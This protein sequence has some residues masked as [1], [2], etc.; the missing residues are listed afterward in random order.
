MDSRKGDM[1]RVGGGFPGKDAGSEDGGREMTDFG[2]NIEHGKVSD[3]Q[4]SFPCRV[5]VSCTGLVNDQ[6]RDVYLE[7]APFLF[8]PFLGDLLV[9]GYD[10]ISAGPRGEI[11]RNRRFQVKFLLHLDAMP[12]PIQLSSQ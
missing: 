4:D 6:L 8:P 9:A 11:A 3:H 12:P 1:R 5:R 2:R 7:C 10:Q